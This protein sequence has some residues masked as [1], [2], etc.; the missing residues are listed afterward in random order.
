MRINLLGVA[1][2]NMKKEEALR[3]VQERLS[4]KR[5]TRIYTPNP[6]MIRTAEKHPAFRSVLNSADLNL[7][8]GAGLLLA[9]RLLSLPLSERIAGIDFAESLLALAQEKEYGIFLLGGRP[10]VAHTAATKL[11]RRFPNLRICGVQH[12][13][14]KEKSAPTIASQIERSGADILLVGLGAP[15]QE[16]WI[17][18]HMPQGLSVAMGVGGSLDVW[19]GTVCRAPAFLSAIGLE[20]LW[21]MIMQ[22]RRAK[23]L[24]LMAA[25]LLSAIAEKAKIQKPV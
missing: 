17:A 23:N 13:Y 15:R 18:R 6:V 2:D 22:P 10:G 16:F 20:W 12:G 24:P 11:K 7:P 9:A 8:D 19:A 5:P 3:Y 1:V 14:F 25:F 21:R 4:Q